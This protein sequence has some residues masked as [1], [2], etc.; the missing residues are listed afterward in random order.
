MLEGD[1][2]SPLNPPPA[3]HFHPRCPRF[4]EGVCDVDDPTMQSF[5]TDHEAKCFY[6]LERWS[7]NAAEMAGTGRK[8]TAE[9]GDEE[10]ISESARVILGLQPAE[11]T[12][13]MRAEDVEREGLVD[14]SGIHFGW[15]WVGIVVG[16]GVLCLLGWLVVNR[17]V[18]RFGVIAALLIVFG[19][20][21]AISYRADKKKRREYDES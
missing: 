10:G 14:E 3:C 17:L 16:V 19:I 9:G 13:V 6:P 11:G 20:L 1:V 8:E 4:H 12:D 7:M 2:P 18:Y 21:M 15:K 5:G